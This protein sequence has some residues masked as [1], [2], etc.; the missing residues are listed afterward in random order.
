M[1]ADGARLFKV[2]PKLIADTAE[3]LYN[4]GFITYPRTESSYYPYNDLTP[5]CEKF[6]EDP[7]FGP[8]AKECIASGNVKSP[9]KGRYSKDHEP[10]TPVRPTTEKEVSEAVNETAFENNLAWRIYEFVTRRFFATIH[11]D[12][13]LKVTKITLM[14][15]EEVFTY[16][17]K[18]IEEKGFLEHYPYR[19]IAVKYSPLVKKND[20]IQV[21]VYSLQEYTVPPDLWTESQLIREMA[22]LNI[23]TDA[24]RSQHIATI[25]NRGFS[26]VQKPK[27]QLLPTEIGKTFFQVFTENAEELIIPKVR[28]TVENWTKQ[29]YTGALNSKQVDN[30]VIDLTEKNLRN[31]Q[32]QK[33]K[34]F[35]I[36]LTAIEKSTKSGTSFG[37]CECG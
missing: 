12:G 35:P 13:I 11:R 15:N 19:K 27:R 9:S 34:I 10:I 36:L 6:L 14:I 7:F 22:R 30:Y 20:K 21:K 8:I 33:D 37:Q 16:E 25:Q 1:E 4:L 28:E 18:I 32:Q 26:K 17:G 2:S 29:I 23:G 3:K 31:L 5:L 24:T